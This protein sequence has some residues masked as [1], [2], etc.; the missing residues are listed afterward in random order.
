MGKQHKNLPNPTD[1]LWT[2]LNGWDNFK[3]NWTEEEQ[4]LVAQYTQKALNQLKVATNDIPNHKVKIRWILGRAYSIYGNEGEERSDTHY[5]NTVAKSI[6]ETLFK[7]ETTEQSKQAKPKNPI[8]KEPPLPDWFDQDEN[9]Q[10]EPKQ[11]K[12]SKE[13][14][15]AQQELDE[16]LAK[17]RNITVEELHKEQQ[18]KKE[19]EQKQEPKDDHKDR[20]FEE[21][22]KKLEESKQEE[23]TR[24]TMA[25]VKTFV[26]GLK[27]NIKAE[28]R[29]WNPSYSETPQLHEQTI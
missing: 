23:N 10:Q 24:A 20:S 1:E 17:S 13:Q 19:Q 15:Q 9:Q 25:D 28:K 3:K 8:R 26:N 27:E 18:A 29:K 7:E 22:L 12:T 14:K 2:V 16:M 11:E 5:Y 4:K 21:L 6:R